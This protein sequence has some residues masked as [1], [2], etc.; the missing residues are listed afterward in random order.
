MTELYKRGNVRQEMSA[1]NFEHRSSH[2]HLTL[3]LTN[4]EYISVTKA[5]WNR[6]LDDLLFL[7]GANSSYRRIR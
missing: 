6:F 4:N 5:A 3:R 7:Y 2:A 1:A